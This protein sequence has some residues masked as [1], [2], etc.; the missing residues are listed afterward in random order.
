[1][2]QIRLLGGVSVAADDGTPLDVGPAKCQ[3][4]LAAL[5]LQPGEVVSVSRL[6][7]MVWGD[8]PP[9]TADKTL[10]SYVTRLRKELD[11]DSIVRTGAAY[12]LNVEPVAVDVVRF[13][14]LLDAGD[15]DAALGEWT[16]QPLA[17]LDAEG[18]SPAVDGLVE[19]WLGALHTSLGRVVDLDPAAAIG[20][21]TELAAQHPF[22][23]GLCALLMTALYRVGRQAD[24]LA[25]YR[26]T[27]Q[28]LVEQL[29]VE[30]DAQLRAL[31]ARILA[32]DAQLGV[33]RSTTAANDR[34]AGTVTFGFADVEDATRAWVT[35]RHESAAA[36]ARVEQ[37][38]RAVAAEHA[39]HVFATRG[40]SFA[41]AFG[42]AADAVAWAGDLQGAVAREPWPRDVA[43]RLR[44]G[45][46]TGEAEAQ[47]DSYFGPAVNLVTCLAAAGHGGQTLVSGATAALLDDGS[48]LRDL[49]THRLDGVP[50]DQR[51]FQLG[52]G[53]HPPVRSSAERRRGNLPRRTARLLGR[54]DEVHLIGQLL[55]E[56]PVVTLVGPGGI[57]K[58][59]L[60]LATAE[61]ADAESVWLVELAEV[62]S[63]ADV[64]RAVAD[65]L[66]VH[67][68]PGRTL[69]DAIVNAAATPTCVRG[70]RQLR[71]RHRRRGEVDRDHPRPLPRRPHP[72]HLARTAGH[73]R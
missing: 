63:S 8:D 24:A 31:E 59:T 27:R 61:V 73:R 37:L 49:G 67:E 43:V 52:A 57:G 41:V 19:Q 72:R 10:Q 20:A 53:E 5:A 2:V 45:V 11:P 33:T 15:V 51:I 47:A 29:G 30:P 3:A 40:D 69:T 26:T 68:S 54:H 9:R 64:T 7:A 16:G 42:R 28:H 46:H 48:D 65:T 25:A 12:R 1:M 66:D 70:A 38:A 34:P 6:V 32:Q 71:T 22:H 50:N 62:A 18:L 17:G 60:A 14:R 58:T 23:E 55:V 35:H 56:S 39:G 13:R 36:M 44:I 4:V 21:L